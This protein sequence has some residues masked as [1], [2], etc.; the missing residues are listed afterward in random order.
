MYVTISPNCKQKQKNNEVT[1]HFAVEHVNNGCNK[2]KLKE[3][4]REREK[5]VAG[6]DNS[7]IN[8]FQMKKFP[9]LFV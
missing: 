5:D 6:D 7:Q 8:L 4:L 1:I 2:K 3:T 9:S